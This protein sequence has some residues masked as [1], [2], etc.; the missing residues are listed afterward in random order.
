MSGV[1]LLKYPLILASSSPRRRELMKLLGLEFS[2]IPA[3]IDERIDFKGDPINHVRALSGAKALVVAEKHPECLVLGADTVVVIDGLILGKPRDS[4]EAKEMLRR[5]SGRD[6][7]VYTGFTL[8]LGGS[9]YS[10]SEVVKSVVTFQPLTEEEIEWYVSTNE[11]YDK[12]GGYAAQGKGAVF[13]KEISGSYT[14]V[15]GLPLCEVIDCLKRE[16]FLIFC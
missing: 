7:L 14:N 15:I 9:N 8:C 12:A 6:H 10:Y 2:A 1:L 16:N 5:L 3:H 4:G 11:P 13:I